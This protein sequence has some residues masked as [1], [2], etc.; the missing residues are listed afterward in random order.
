MTDLV[1]APIPLGDWGLT[2]EY[3]AKFQRAAD[4]SESGALP[5]PAGTRSHSRGMSFAAVEVELG[6]PDR[7]ND[8]TRI[9][10]AQQRWQHDAY[11]FYDRLPEI[12]YPANFIGAALSRF[13]WPIG[14]IPDDSPNEEAIVPDN[15][16]DA[17]A[18]FGKAMA[19]VWLTASQAIVD[20]QGMLGGPNALAQLYGINATV[21]AEC[22]L[23]GETKGGTDDWCVYSIREC[24]A[25]ND[26]RLYRN[27]VD[28][29]NAS[30]EWKPAYARRFWKPHPGRLIQADSAMGPLTGDCNRLVA[31]NEAITARILSR[32][33]TAGILY[34][35]QGV[36]IAGQQVPSGND[37]G[38]LTSS[39]IWNHLLTA[40]EMSIRNPGS[41][42]GAVPMILQGPS[43]VAE[44]IRHIV[45][46]RTIDRVE[47]EL[48]AELRH[49]IATGLD[50][51]P[52]VQTGLSDTNH[53]T[54]WSVMDSS[55]RTHLKPL[56][57]QWANGL[58]RV[59]VKPY[60]LDA[61][62][63]P[64][65]VRRLD[66]VADGCDVIA[67]PNESEDS[68]QAV[69]RLAISLRSFR[70][71]NG[72]EEDDAPNEEEYVRQLGIKVNVPYLATWG[73]SVHDEID[74]AQV[75]GAAKDG[76]PGVGGTPPSRT[77]A[78][79][80]KV[81]P[82]APG[83]GTAGQ[84]KKKATEAIGE[85]MATAAYHALP[86]ALA[87]VGA[88]V[89][90]LAND[91]QHPDLASDLKPIPNDRVLSSFN[92]DD[93][94]IDDGWVTG[95]ITAALLSVDKTVHRY[96]DNFVAL[97][98]RL[99]VAEAATASMHHPLTPLALTA[100]AVR[101]LSAHQS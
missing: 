62:A 69:D 30:M 55:F 56:A 50:L 45:L 66:V 8:L 79:S 1:P 28:V 2:P 97:D 40:I 49:N 52:E 35:P 86:G 21:A 80:G 11:G 31:L 53:W 77:P 63:D 51:P 92:W 91:G 13:E 99:S 42:L 26:G 20:L 75:P 12:H 4:A 76:A 59:Y 93:L 94:D 44:A 9:A 27:N 41:A 73:M 19:D 82:G 70:D 61:G 85:I 47:M 101:V 36:T 87:R 100:I 7:N 33:A 90:G 89:R 15:Y 43:D 57:D 16:A 95:Q 24:V 65:L 88:K 96:A 58:L 71:K 17:K 6:A 98:F 46:D 34:I 22:W 14:V 54:S 23:I 83:Q 64:E 18:R 84:D 78:D 48:R 37:P 38:A 60:C 81:G 68:R 32:L 5:L 74:W 29:G 10:A 67:R 3:R 72:Y 39:P 25:G